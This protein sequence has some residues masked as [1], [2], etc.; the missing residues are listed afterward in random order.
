MYARPRVRTVEQTKTDVRSAEVTTARTTTTVTTARTTTRV[1][2]ARTVEAT[3]PKLRVRTR[4]LSAGISERTGVTVRTVRLGPDVRRVVISESRGVQIGDRN[5]QLNHFRYRVERPRV[6]VDRLF[7]GHPGRLR[8]FARLVENP[9]SVMANSAFRRR[10]SAREA[11][12]SSRVRFAETSGPGIRRISAP[13]DAQG[14]LVVERSRGVQTGERNTQ[15]NRFSYRAVN[16]ELS[17]EQMLRGHP[18][19]TRA[20]A[21]AARHPANE[22]AQ[23]SFARHIAGAYGRPSEQ[24]SRLVGAGRAGSGLAVDRGAGVQYGTRNTRKD[25]VSVDFGRAVVT[26]WRSVRDIESA[27]SAR[28]ASSRRRRADDRFSSRTDSSRPAPLL[29]SRDPRTTRSDP[30]TTRSDPRTSRREPRISG[31]EW[32]E[33]DRRDI[34]RSSRDTSRDTTARPGQRDNRGGGF[35]R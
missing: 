14:A 31:R 21:L 11:E 27:A 24:T 9:Y 8:A 33:R 5:R 15:H 6:S 2:T 10:L 32:P 7:K 1:T 29:A 18:G 20:L 12:L 34:S 13:V 17:L 25:I 22:A 3:A 28:A 30:R 16:P 35:G 19:L 23:R 4:K 26:G